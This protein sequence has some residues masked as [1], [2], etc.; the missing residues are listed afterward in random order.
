M[1]PLALITFHTTT[2]KYAFESNF[3]SWRRAHP[4]AKLSISR[5]KPS[6]GRG[7]N[8]ILK[9]EEIRRNLGQMYNSE[10]A[11]F[12]TEDPTS[13][14]NFTQLS[15]DQI[16]AIPVNQ[17]V[18]YRPFAMYWEYLCPSNNITFM[19]YTPGTNPFIHYEFDK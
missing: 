5:P 13:L 3:D 9:I 2:D 16:N 6:K 4:K 10:I 14:H 11:K 17:K 15:D 7:D 12:N 18:K 1:N 8:G 19:N